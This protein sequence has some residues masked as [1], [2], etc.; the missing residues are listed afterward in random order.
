[1]FVDE[2]LSNFLIATAKGGVS[3]LPG[4]GL[5]A[6]YIGL[7]QS[8]IAD[9]RMNEWKDKVEQILSIIPKSMSELAESEEFY[10]CMQTATIGAMRA[11][12]EEKRKYFANALYQSAVNDNLDTD[13][14]LFFLRLLDEYTLCHIKLLHY[15]SID[16]FCSEDN[17][18][19]NGMVTITTMGETEYPIKGIIEFFPEYKNDEPFIRNIIKQLVADGL[20][21][22]I[23]FNI[24]VSKERSRCKRITL[25]GEELLDFIKQDNEE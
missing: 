18:K 15:F 21:N 13:K 22:A 20:I 7:A 14:K 12:Q 5:L 6:E 19:K 10:S 24:P 2:K 17:V 9:K 25:F 11:F 8:S 16:H 3:L 1:M 23:E 4:G